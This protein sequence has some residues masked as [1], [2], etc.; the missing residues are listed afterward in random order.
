MLSN[1]VHIYVLQTGTQDNTTPSFTIKHRN[2]SLLILDS[3]DGP[4][5]L[6]FVQADNTTDNH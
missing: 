2:S 6:G 3:N 5:S 1:D 4:K